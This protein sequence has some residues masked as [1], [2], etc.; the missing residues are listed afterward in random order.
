MTRIN[1]AIEP[2]ELCD[3]HLLAEYREITRVP[4]QAKNWYDKGMKGKLPEDF[5]LGTGHVKFFYNKVK[6]LHLRFLALIQEMIRRGN[7]ANIE[8]DRF[9]LL[10]DTEI[11]NDWQETKEARDLLY[12]RIMERLQGKEIK[13][14]K[15]KISHK[16]YTGKIFCLY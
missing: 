15:E 3:Q 4:T 10:K 1:A 8:D 12:Q 9:L 11:Y 7:E 16:V 5:R 2:K 14:Y 6:Y 13:Y